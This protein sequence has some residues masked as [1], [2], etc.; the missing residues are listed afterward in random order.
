MAESLIYV[1]KAGCIH[2]P[3]DLNIEEIVK[4]LHNCEE[5]EE[6]EGKVIPSF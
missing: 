3:K 2:P 6:E 1:P 5:L 4:D